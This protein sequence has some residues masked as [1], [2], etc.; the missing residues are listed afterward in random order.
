M[1]WT[2]GCISGA[3][4]AGVT[5]TKEEGFCGGAG[6]DTLGAEDRSTI[7]GGNVCFFFSSKNL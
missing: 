2:V 1:G 4:G 7:P 6:I 5:G 3:E